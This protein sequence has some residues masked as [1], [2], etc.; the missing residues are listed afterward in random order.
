MTDAA[1]LMLDRWRTHAEQGR[2]VD[3]FSEMMRLTLEIV[4]RT[5]LSSDVSGDTDAV[6]QAVTILR[7]HVNYRAMRLFTLPERFPT[8]R[9]LR[10]KRA[11]RTVD[12]VVYGMIEER[13]RAGRDTG[14]LLSMLL[15]TRDE[16]T[17]EGM[18]DKQLRDEVMTIFLAGHET[19]ASVLAWTWYLLSAH[20]EV[21][22]RLHDELSQVLDGRPPTFEDL[23]H[24]KYTRMVIEESIRLYPPAWSVGRTAIADDEIGG[25]RIPANSQV[26]LSPYVTHRH[27]AFWENPERFDPERFTPERVAER[28]RYAYFPFGGGPRQCIGNEFAMMEAQLI[29]A[30]VAKTYRLRQ[31]PGH[32][33]EPEPVITLRPRHGVLMDVHKK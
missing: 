22:G 9:N 26:T 11:L 33:V 13:R 29:L 20:P 3:V 7:E 31:I 2:A 19:T 24:L 21:E 10:F 14:D 30:M 16:E 6:G 1:E 12:T 18:S 4:G 23:P 32:P 15:L 27:R 5:L 17:G 25:Y 28:P 8:P